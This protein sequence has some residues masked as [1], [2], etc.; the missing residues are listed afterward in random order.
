MVVADLT[1]AQVEVEEDPQVDVDSEQ[2]V[3]SAIQ[4]DLV[5]AE[6]CNFVL[7]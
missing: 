5:V 6:E 3:D 1:E 2:A 4:V 7:N